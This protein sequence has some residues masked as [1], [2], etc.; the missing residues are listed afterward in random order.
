M[1][2]YEC[3]NPN[4]TLKEIVHDISIHGELCNSRNGMTLA[5]K[6]PVSI[7]H[8]DPKRRVI[9]LK[10]RNANPFFHIFEF[11]WMLAGR[12]DVKTISAFNGN[13]KS[14]SD[15][16]ISFNAPYGYRL[17][18]H[19]GHDQL[20]EVIEILKKDPDSRQAV[21]LLWDNADLTKNTKDKAC[22]LELVFKVRDGK[23]DM[24]VFNRS[25]DLIWGALGANLVHMSF[26]HEYVATK[27]GIPMGAYEQ[28]SNCLHVY[29]DGVAGNI[30]KNI[31]AD[32][33]EGCDYKVRYINTRNSPS[34]VGIDEDV[35]KLFYHIGICKDVTGMMSGFVQEY[36]S[37]FFN[38]LF[39]PM[40]MTYAFHKLKMDTTAMDILIGSNI[41]Q[42]WK[43]ACYNWLDNRK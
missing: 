18:H 12:K 27:I 38:R 6:E 16:G 19:F 7:R 43:L 36:Q 29:T 41:P 10:S 17:K 11:V 39:I 25:N 14:Y 23:L 21:A 9:W 42:D 30:L 22:N 8:I 32:D 1:I 24:T 28:V 2:E 5:F 4:L 37:D 26:F 31:L 13:M 20:N 3:E 15:D 35:S 34:M 40:M 33:P